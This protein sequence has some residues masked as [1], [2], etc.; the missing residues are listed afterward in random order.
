VAQLAGGGSLTSEAI[1]ET[2]M[3]AAVMMERIAEGSPRPR[4]R[5]TGVIYLL[6]FLTA[7]S[8]EVFV[9]HS[10]LVL[11]DAVNLI[12]YA[13]YIAVTLLFYYLFKPVN[14]SLSL[15]AVLFSLAGCANDLL[16]LFHLAHYKINSLVF[17]GPYCLLIGYLIFRSTF[18][19]GILGVL[20]ALAGLGWLIFLTPLAN[21]LSTYLKVLGFLAEMSLMLWLIVKGV[22]IQ[23]WKEQAS[24]AVE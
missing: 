14:R 18:L 2:S 23:K 3:T 6:Y 13:F 15:L 24:A 22:N 19:P 9:G 1:G 8:A 17:F 10:R 11:Y 21:H 20:M 16:D 12:A 5:T 7:V 4:A